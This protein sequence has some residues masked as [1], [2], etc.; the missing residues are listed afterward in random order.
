MSMNSEEVKKEKTPA[1][2]SRVVIRFKIHW[3]VVFTHFP[4]SI[5][6]VSFG[7]MT[8]HLITQASCFELASYLSLIGGAVVMVPTTLTGWYTWKNRYTGL[9]SR[10]FSNKIRISFAMIGISFALAAYRGIGTMEFVSFEQHAIYF[11]GVT[12][13]LL[14]AVA[15]GYYGGRLNH[16]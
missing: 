7:F 15:E 10:I 8:L 14:G 12:L 13:L 16:R 6:M 2:I 3:H 5:F 1:G 4:V 11:T 9:K